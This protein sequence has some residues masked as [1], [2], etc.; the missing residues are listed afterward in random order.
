M[1]TA[2]QM[3]DSP[4]KVRFVVRQ[5]QKH[6]LVRVDEVD[7]F[8]SAGNYVRLHTTNGSYLIRST[9]K[10]LE[11]S[12]DPAQFG[13]IHR[14]AMVNLDRVAEIRHAAFGDYEITLASGAKLRMS[15]HYKRNILRA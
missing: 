11:A 12:L 9:L 2:L 1:Q 6:Y 15:R 5:R 8:E 14:S 13:R 4:Y 10:D 3:N 7:W